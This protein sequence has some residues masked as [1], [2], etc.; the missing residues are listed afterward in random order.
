MDKFLTRRRSIPVEVDQWNFFTGIK[1]HLYPKMSHEQTSDLKLKSHKQL[2]KWT[3]P[4]HRGIKDICDSYSA[5]KTY[6]LT[7]NDKGLFCNGYNGQPKICQEIGTTPIP[8]TQVYLLS[9]WYSFGGK[10][11]GTYTSPIAW[12]MGPKWQDYRWNW[13]ETRRFCW[14]TTSQQLA[15]QSPWFASEIQP[16]KCKCTLNNETPLR[17]SWDTIYKYKYIYIHSNS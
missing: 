16:P 9:F 15:D 4:L 14:A 12:E 8:N 17:A 5:Q 2:V 6:V 11:V 3:S 13:V 10:L 7:P 1:G